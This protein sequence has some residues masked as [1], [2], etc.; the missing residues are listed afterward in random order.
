MRV[1]HDASEEEE[2]EEKEKK[3]DGIFGHR[4]SAVGMP[5][6]SPLPRERGE[7]IGRGREER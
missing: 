4:R 5:I 1:L 2:E 3:E 6:S 7:M